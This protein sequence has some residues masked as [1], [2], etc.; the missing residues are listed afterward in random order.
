MQKIKIKIDYKDLR[1]GRESMRFYFL[2]Q[3]HDVCLGLEL[4]FNGLNILLASKS[5]CRFFGETARRYDFRVKEVL[6]DSL[7]EFDFFCEIYDFVWGKF[8]SSLD[9]RCNMVKLYRTI[10]YLPPTTIF[11]HIWDYFEIVKKQQ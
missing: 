7:D 5:L 11:S 2:H 8:G 9:A 3:Y 10:R 4:A 1:A 6:Q